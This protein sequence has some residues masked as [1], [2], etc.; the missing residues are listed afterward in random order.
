MRYG[1]QPIRSGGAVGAFLHR[2][3]CS[4]AMDERS[5]DLASSSAAGSPHISGTIG[6]RGD[7]PDALLRML[8]RAT[9]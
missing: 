8:I 1:T 3:F 9:V 5:S 2:L 6:E 7:H 4:G